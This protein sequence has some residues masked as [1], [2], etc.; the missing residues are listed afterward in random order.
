MASAVAST[1]GRGVEIIEKSEKSD[2][3]VPCFFS[4]VHGLTWTN[5]TRVEVLAETEG[6]A[7]E[8]QTRPTQQL[9]FVSH[10]VRRGVLSD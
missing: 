1:M 4:T 5:N 2:L 10:P 3:T 7:V 8:T 9:D 6:S